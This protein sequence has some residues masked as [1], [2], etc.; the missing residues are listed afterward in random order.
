M[1]IAC[2]VSSKM[3]SLAKYRSVKHHT[4]HVFG[5]C[6]DIVPKLVVAVYKFYS[7]IIYFCSCVMLTWMQL[8]IIEIR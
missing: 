1:H 8:I 3:Q 7:I 6:K 5:E 2:L 4:D